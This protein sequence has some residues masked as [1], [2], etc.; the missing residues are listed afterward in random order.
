MSIYFCEAFPPKELNT[1]D[2]FS[3]SISAVS[4][5]EALLKLSKKIDQMTC[6]DFSGGGYMIPTRVTH[7]G[8]GEKRTVSIGL[9]DGRILHIGKA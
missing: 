8:S 6:G 2:V 3:G 1:V 4:Q 9:I 7:V 5:E